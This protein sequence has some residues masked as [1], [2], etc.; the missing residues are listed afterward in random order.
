MEKAS[1]RPRPWQGWG[2]CGAEVRRLL[3][4]VLLTA[5]PA[6]GVTAKHSECAGE[7]KTRG[8]PQPKELNLIKPHSGVSYGLSVAEG[9]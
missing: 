1:D 3:C 9:S 6:G 4:S 7:R 8:S 2:L 5:L